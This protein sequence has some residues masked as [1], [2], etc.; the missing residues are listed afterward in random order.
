MP[1]KALRII[2]TPSGK[3]DREMVMM[4]IDQLPPGD[5]LIKVNYSALNFKDALSATG[6]KGITKKYPHVP[7]VDAAGVVEISRSENFLVNE[8]VIVTGH[9][10]GMNTSGGFA[11]YIRIPSYWAVKKPL[12][13]SFSESMTIGT[14]GF[15]A[16]LALYKMQLMGQNPGIG[17]IVVTGATGG[18]GSLAIAML[19]KAGYEVIAV[20]GK[21]NAREYLEHL[22]ATRIESREFVNDA[23]GKALLKPKWAGAID[24]VGGNTLNTLLKG[25]MSEGSVA[26]TGLVDSPQL[27]VTVFPF[28]L[29]GVNL[30]GIA[31][32][33]TP[34]STRALIWKKILMEWNIKEKL[35]VIA[36]EVSLEELN[37]TYIDAILEGKIMGRIVVK[38]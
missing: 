34:A 12:E 2:E 3:F 5:L 21:T 8:E 4:E 32:A 24:T 37:A 18:V 26:T 30:L 19:A 33:E 6:N 1:F 31:S 28:I 29:N 20:T 38:I 22:G 11:E 15:T 7:G 25:C 17:P 27:P 13:L 36:K 35:S 23:S 14:A 9:D 16:A 10:L